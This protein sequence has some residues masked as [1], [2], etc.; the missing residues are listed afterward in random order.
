M[1]TT[2]LTTG[3][4]CVIA[5][6]VGGGVKLFGGSVPVIPSS[7]R[8]LGLGVFGGV[9]L[10]AAY[11]LTASPE[12]PT[13]QPSSERRETTSV[14]ETQWAGTMKLSDLTDQHLDVSD[15][16]GTLSFHAAPVNASKLT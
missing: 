9:L 15:E 12:K 8:Q 5:A 1:A 7:M 14:V 3:L 6:I 4:V 10:P 2:L 16:R 13:P 11:L